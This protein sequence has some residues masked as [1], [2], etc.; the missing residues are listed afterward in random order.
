MMAQAVKCLPEARLDRCAI[1]DPSEDGRL[2]IDYG[3]LREPLQG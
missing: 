2:G 3:K 1:L